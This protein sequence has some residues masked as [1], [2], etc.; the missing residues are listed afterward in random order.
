MIL[1]VKKLNTNAT[2]PRYATPGAACFDLHAL[3]GGLIVPGC[4]QVFGT[5]LAFEIPFGH[6]MQIFVRS[7]LAFNEGVRL[8]NSTGIIDP[9]YRG[10]VRIGLH[11][12][13]QYQVVISRGDRIA[14]AMIVAAPRVEIVEVSALSETERGE[15]GFGST[16]K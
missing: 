2:L 16:G 5:G 6:V 9:D 1:T 14:Q 8:V 15:G 10:E 4:A 11:N 3:E 13:G 12:A 7:G